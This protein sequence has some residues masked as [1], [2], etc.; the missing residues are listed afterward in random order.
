MTSEANKLL[1][2]AVPSYNAGSFL[3]TCLSSFLI[4]R[5]S[6]DKLEIIVVNDGSTDDT[7]DVAMKY[8]LTYPHVYCLINKQNG[9]HGS[10]IN[11]AIQQAR[12]KYFKVVDADDWVISENLASLLDL[13]STS[14][15]DVILA[16]FNAVD[17]NSRKK[18]EYKTRDIPLN[19]LYTLDEFTALQGEIY[20]CTELHGLTYRTEVYRRSGTVLSE[21][22]FYEDQ[23]YATLPFTVVQT[24]FPTDLFLYE[25]LVGNA[26]QSVSDSNQVK[27]LGDMEQ[28][29]KKLFAC[30][31]KSAELSEGQRRYIAH[32]AADMLGDYYQAALIKNPDKK[33]GRAQAARLR[34][35]LLA[36]EP[37]L[38]STADTKYRLSRIM[39]R[40][41]FSGKTLSRLK[42]PLP[43]TLFRKLFKRSQ[44]W[45]LLPSRT[46]VEAEYHCWHPE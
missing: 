19:V 8:V 22:I 37:A 5:P 34:N 35:E 12:G 14:D 2:I 25:Y 42:S 38:V 26:S 16:H 3:D 1:T 21:G 39:G 44:C 33:G 4:E 18:K 20:H 45:Q 43:Y 15:A 27:R 31:H 11:A 32:K 6:F 17:M 10:G 30:Y 29:A 23:E 13:L 36:L 28:V 46:S 7:A 41:G 24:V 9:G 40:L